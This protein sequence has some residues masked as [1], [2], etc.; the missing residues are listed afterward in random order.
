MLS[1]RQSVEDSLADAPEPRSGFLA[2]LPQW[3]AA[4][5]N[6]QQSIRKISYF[7]SITN[8]VRGGIF[9]VTDSARSR[10]FSITGRFYS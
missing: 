1:S 9:L 10:L 8:A 3:Q 4:I 2:P 5:I 7:L 6:A